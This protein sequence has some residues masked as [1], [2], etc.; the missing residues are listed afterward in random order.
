VALAQKEE[1][2]RDQARAGAG[3][4]AAADA[5]AH[6]N[7]ALGL[8]VVLLLCLSS[9]FAGV[10]FEKVLKQTSGGLVVR[11]LQLGSLSLLLALWVVGVLASHA[12]LWQM[13]LW[14]VAGISS[15]LDLLC[16]ADAIWAHGLFEPAALTLILLLFRAKV[17]GA[18][19]ASAWR[20]WRL[21]R[22]AL[23]VGC[24]F[25][26]LQAVPLVIWH[27]TGKSERLGPQP[28]LPMN[29]T[30]PADP[31]APDPD[32]SPASLD[33][34][35][36]AAGPSAGRGW[37]R[38]EGCASGYGG[39]IASCLF[40]GPFVLLWHVAC[41]RLSRTLINRRMRR[42]LRLVHASF[43]L[44]PALL[45]L[46]RASLL[47]APPT[48]SSYR[49][50]IRDFE[51]LLVAYACVVALHSLVWRPVHEGKGLD[52]G[53]AGHA[54]DDASALE[55][56]AAAESTSSRAACAGEAAGAPADEHAAC[57]SSMATPPRPTPL[58][59]PLSRLFMLGRHSSASPRRPT[60]NVAVDLGGAGV[61]PEVPTRLPQAGSGAIRLADVHC[62]DTGDLSGQLRVRADATVAS[63]GLRVPDSPALPSSSPGSGLGTEERI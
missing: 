45:V 18:P 17:A 10:Y 12:A 63:P 25:A 8:S 57:A 48:W 19:T 36:P 3:G 29:G 21:I 6:R 4:A 11:N 23:G 41:H 40:V 16:Q 60:L 53:G 15:Q 20:P 1:E 49:R 54:A 13:A 38:L 31:V 42:R 28:V 56:A 52:S 26:V 2:V 59:S 32:A 51:L 33:E 14:H 27:T 34:A 43:A 50:L 9:G 5:A 61:S 55:R 24:G 37:W 30:W 62:P 46:I 58:S 35:R 7:T 39:L 22:V 47:L 44:A